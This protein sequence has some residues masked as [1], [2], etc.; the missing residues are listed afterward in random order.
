MELSRAN[1]PQCVA[2]QL[3]YVNNNTKGGVHLAPPPCNWTVVNSKVTSSRALNSDLGGK[4]SNPKYYFIIL[5][6][7]YIILYYHFTD[8]P[9]YET[10]LDRGRSL[11]AIVQPVRGAGDNKYVVALLFGSFI[12]VW[13]YIQSTSVAHLTPEVLVSSKVPSCPHFQTFIFNPTLQWS[14]LA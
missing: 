7:I 14:S 13:S 10:D 2:N 5:L 9:L 1:Y 11:W 12:V 8:F 3:I 6:Y 4:Q